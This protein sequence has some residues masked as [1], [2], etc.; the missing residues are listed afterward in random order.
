MATFPWDLPS[1]CGTQYE[2]L[3]AYHMGSMMYC[4]DTEMEI[5]TVLRLFS[6]TFLTPLSNH[7]GSL[8]VGRERVS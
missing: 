2:N 7:F 5:R 6:V 3:S 8:E 4:A 1:V